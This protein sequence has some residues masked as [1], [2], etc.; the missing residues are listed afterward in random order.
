VKQFKTFLNEGLE[1]SVSKTL[2]FSKKTKSEAQFIANEAHK[3]LR[4]LAKTLGKNVNKLIDKNNK[5]LLGEVDNLFNHIEKT[6][7]Q[8]T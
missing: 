3:K 4:E 2:K 6:L 8:I 7:R 5:P 1:K